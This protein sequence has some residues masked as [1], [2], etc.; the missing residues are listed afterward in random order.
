MPEIGV[1]VAV[2]Q[3]EQIL[4]TKREDFEVWCLPGGSV[5]IGESIAEAA[6]REVW[7]ETGL[8]VRLTRLVG[9]YS[10]PNWHHEGSHIALFAAELLGGYLNLQPAEVIEAQFFMRDEI[11]KV[12]LT[13]Q[14]QRIE[15]AFNEKGGCVVWSQ[16]SIWPFDPKLNRKE[17]YA[18]R[19]QSGLAR[20]EFYQ[21]YFSSFEQD[22]MVL[23]VG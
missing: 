1:N 12:L 23:E 17:I 10:R 4:L 19:D 7:E 13:G 20:S 9:L 6:V 15:D 3:D 5:D 14:K 8:I 22:Q 2:F 18:L 11:P 21:R 16:R